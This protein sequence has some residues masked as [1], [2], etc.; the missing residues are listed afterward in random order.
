MTKKK[1]VTALVVLCFMGMFA[2]A[3]QII[4]SCQN[5]VIDSLTHSWECEESST[6][7][8]NDCDVLLDRCTVSGICGTG[9]GGGGCNPLTWWLCD[10]WQL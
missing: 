4:A 9:A 7:G 10:P 5:C 6:S 1:K 2:I 8:G 3:P